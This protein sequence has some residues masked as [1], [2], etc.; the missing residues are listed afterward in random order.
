MIILEQVYVYKNAKSQKHVLIRDIMSTVM[1]GLYT[2]SIVRPLVFPLIMFLPNAIMGRDIIFTESINLGPAWI[3]FFMVIMFYSFL[4]YG[5]HRI[6]HTIPFLWELHSYHHTVTDIRASNL[7]VSHPLDYFNRNSLPPII[8]ALIG[9]NHTA[10]LVAVGVLG[11]M[12]VF[13]HCGSAAR[14][15]WLNSI[16]MTP[17]VHRWPYAIITP[18]GHEYSVNYGVGFNVWDRIFGTFY[19]PYKDGIPEQPEDMATRMGM[20]MR[21]II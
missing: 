13:S 8:L 20:R 4:R 5:A 7:L 10:L 3:Q 16:F 11:T 9:F 6:Q 2:S 18:K 14:A 21:K 15:G 17:E 1:N 12:S 19:L